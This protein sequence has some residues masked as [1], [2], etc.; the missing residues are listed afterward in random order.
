M[1]LVLMSRAEDPAVWRRA[2]RTLAPEIDF[3]VWPEIGNG[4]DITMLACNVDDDRE[5]GAAFAA[6]P[7]LRCVVYLG[8]GAG[9]VLLSRFLPRGVPVLRLRDPGIIRSMVEYVALY[10]LRHHRREPLYVEQQR[11]HV[12]Q[13]YFPPPTPTVRLGVMG[14]GA[15]GAPIARMMRALGF[16]VSGW[17]RTRH[18]IDGVA[19]YAGRAGLEPFLA[20]L[21]YVACVL[22]LTRETES[23]IDAGTIAAMKPGAYFL[24]IGR[25][26]LVVEED[27][28]AALDS[29]HLSGAVLDVFRT[30]PLPADSPFWDHPKVMVTPHESGVRTEASIPGIVA[31]YRRLKGGEPLLGIADP[32]RGY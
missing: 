24:N 1:P 6:M 30:E 14:L 25:G 29:G 7:A 27:L 9:D 19:G 17:A 28:L 4:A 2:V 15:I 31:N 26:R 22:P 23:I 21:D 10:V 32:A 20:P 11:R 18:E 8:H 16:R 13:A 3:R 12:W 5:L